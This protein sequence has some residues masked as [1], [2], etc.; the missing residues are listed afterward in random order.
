MITS[1]QPFSPHGY[2]AEHMRLPFMAVGTCWHGTDAFCATQDAL[3][4]HLKAATVL[5]SGVRPWQPSSGH[6][7]VSTTN[8]ALPA[9][10]TLS[11][12]VFHT[13]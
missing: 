7:L 10:T 8:V 12:D 3:S 9:T 6:E 1:A 5:T 11:T 13:V 2:S 4:D